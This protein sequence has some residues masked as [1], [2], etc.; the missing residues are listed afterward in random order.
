MRRVSPLCLL[1]VLL[2]SPVT[3]GETAWQE[4]APG[5]KLRLISTGQVKANGTTLL[6][7]EID[8]PETTKTYWRVPGDTG[9]P[10]ELDFSASTG[11]LAHQIL[12]PYP[13]RHEGADYLDYAYFGPTV[14]PIE[15]TVAPD[16]TEIALTAVLGVCSDICVPAQAKFSLPKGD[17]VPDRPNGLRIRQALATWPMPW[18]GDPQPLGNVEYDAA[19]G[20]LLVHVGDPDLD[21]ASLIASTDSGEPLFGTPQKSPEP[22]LVL[23]PILAQGDEID[24]EGRDVQLTFMTGMG[25]FEVSRPVKVLRPD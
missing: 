3:A 19:A 2:A 13:V 22:N 10:T 6:G 14:L 7:L 25:A 8:M 21:P 4:V 23:I 24:L 16:A 15:V 12:W 17:A 18:E 20:Q 11:V 5:V 9:L 1:A